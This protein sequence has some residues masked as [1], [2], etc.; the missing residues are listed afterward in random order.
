MIQP[1]REITFPV[2]ENQKKERIDLYLVKRLSSVSRS[3]VKQLID[4]G[5]V[6]VNS[7]RVKPS[8]LVNPGETIIV[9]LQPRPGPS[10]E[11]EDIPLDIIYE[12]D[13]LIVVNKPAGLVVHPAHGNWSGTL[14]NALL[15]HNRRLSEFGEGFRAGLVHRLDKDTSG[16]IVAAKDEYTSGELGKQ[17]QERTIERSYISLVWGRPKKDSG[18]I[19]EN[20]GRS[21]RDRKIIAVRPDGKPAVTS[22][23]TLELF[24]LF[25]LLE[26]RLGTGRTHQIRV[27]LSH[28]GHP[29]F[30][31]PT[32]GGRNA[33]F[34]NLTQIQRH[35]C[36]VLLEIMKRQALH[37]RTLGFTHPV[38]GESINIDS[39]LPDDFAE[40]LK[41][42]R[43]ERIY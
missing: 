10:F 15:G 36:A 33:R 39:E 35:K 20:I 13:N 22:Y 7:E 26:L 9:H 14:M 30:G 11:P 41:R 40:L 8:H 31:D 34:G 28:Q 16:L 42:L 21:K 27:H 2:A 4:A 32:Y 5:L 38:T 29:V 6:T 18:V 23:R 43:E 17:F 25:S 24:E 19:E 12:D 1:P 3:R 37:A